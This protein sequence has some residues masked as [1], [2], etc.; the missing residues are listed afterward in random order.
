MTQVWFCLLS[1]CC[2]QGAVKCEPGVL[3]FVI[4]LL[5][6]NVNQ[7]C[8]CLLSICCEQGAVKCEP[9]VVLFVIH[10]LWARCC[11]VWPRCGFVCYP[12]AV[13]KVL[14]NVNQ[15]WFCLLSICCEQGAVK[16]EPGVLLFVI[17]LLWARCC[18]VWTRCGFVCYPFAVSKV[19]WNVNQVWFCLLSICCEQGAVKCEPGVVLFVIHLLWAR[20]CEMW[21][22]CGFVCYPFA[23][24]KVLWNVN[25]VCFCLLSICC[26][27][28]AVKCEPGVLLFVIHLLWARCCEVWTR[29][30]FVCYPF[31][32][33]KVLWNVNQV[34]FCL[35][36]ICCEQGAVKCE[37]G[38]LLFVI[39]LLWARCC[40]MWTRCGFVCY[41]FAVSK[42]LWNVNQVWICLLSICCEQGAVKCEPGVVLFVIHLLWTRC[43]EVW[44]RCAFVCYPF[45]VSKVLWSVNQVWICLLSIC[46]EQGAV[47]CEP[48][49]DLFVIHL[50]W[51]RCCEMWTRC[52]FVCYPFAVN[53]VLWSVNQVWFCLLS[54]CCEQGAVKCEPGVDLF[55]IH[56]L[57]ARCCE[58]WTRCGFVCYPFA[59][60]KVLW[61]ASKVWFCLLPICSEQGAVNCDSG[62]VLFISKVLWCVSQV[63]FCLLSICCEQG[64]VKC[65]PGVVLFITH[66]LWA[67]CCEVWA[68]CGFVCYPFA[69]TKETNAV[70]PH[71][72]L[73]IM[74]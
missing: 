19:L 3:L 45:A 22:R 47:K 23:V 2:E 11:E 68:R 14:W 38:V 57:W 9:G 58:V 41:P 32:V 7:V 31:A 21:T 44:T 43:C 46:C 34:C 10:L 39:H 72:H 51:A 24:S 25:Q 48:G 55:V 12:F 50:L 62:V 66:S 26:E 6:W 36:S 28:G 15:V 33:S 30:G 73:K 27:Q 53:K 4:H 69:V 70:H 29:C 49:V 13:S 65:E 8:F 59:V 37:P 5:L 60:S 63:W 64:A 71:W 67:R 74:V 40:E 20:C 18:E 42:V 54:I 17:H 61:S 52:G 1:I 56:L 35:L 16:C